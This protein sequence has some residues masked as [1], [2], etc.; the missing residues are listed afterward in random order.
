M[1]PV[2]TL[3]AANVVASLF[4][5]ASAHAFGLPAAL[6]GAP[7]AN[8]TSSSS[9]D[10]LASQDALVKAFVASE[11]EVLTAESLLEQ[12]YGKKDTAKLCDD[13][14]KALQNTS[15]D[16]DT[17]EKTV[18]VSKKAG[19]EIA[20]QQSKQA[21]LSDDEKKFYIQSL[22]HFAKG[23]I[24]THDVVTKAATFASGLKGSGSNIGGMLSGG[25]LKL[26]SGMFI[27][28]ST[29]EYSKNLFEVFRK[30]VMIGQNS[31]VKIP[32]D[33]TSA[34]GDL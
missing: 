17:L 25:M 30:T 21:A 24:G 13:Q 6:G 2:K 34:L 33:A 1:K 16:S 5:A 15:V 7:S 3:I 18:D 20:D 31:G 4:I 32:A 26:K 22:P 10:N 9:N 11:I 27:A 23:V 29:P 28:K 8:S 19:A 14:V 12:A